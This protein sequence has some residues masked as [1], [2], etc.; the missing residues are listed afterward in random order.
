MNAFRHGQVEYSAFDRASRLER[1]TFLRVILETQRSRCRENRIAFRCLFTWVQAQAT[2]EGVVVRANASLV[3][4]RQHVVDHTIVLQQINDM[5][6]RTP[7]TRVVSC[8]TPSITFFPTFPRATVGR[9]LIS[10]KE[11]NLS[12]SLTSYFLLR[13]TGVW[14]IPCVGNKTEMQTRGSSVEIDKSNLFV[15]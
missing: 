9:F 10:P 2:P 8:L 3:V 12:S 6:K 4:H 7:P 13:V 11:G 14:L 1:G 5:Q 15:F